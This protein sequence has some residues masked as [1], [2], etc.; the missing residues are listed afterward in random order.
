MKQGNVRPVVRLAAGERP[1]VV[2][3]A[4]DGHPGE[5][6]RSDGVCI[7]SGGAVRTVTPDGVVLVVGWRARLG[8]AWEALRGRVRL[9]PAGL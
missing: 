3:R 2:W 4:G 5:A 6:A 7:E 8:A 9:F 1:R